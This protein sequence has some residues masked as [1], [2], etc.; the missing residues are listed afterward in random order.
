MNTSCDI[1]VSGHSLDSSYFI[2]VK[3]VIVQDVLL[4]LSFKPGVEFHH[5]SG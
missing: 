4:S 3:L 5:C 2:T 1:Y